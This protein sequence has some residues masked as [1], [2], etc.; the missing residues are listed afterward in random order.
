M[1]S[2]KRSGKFEKF[3]PIAWFRSVVLA[4]IAG[5]F[6]LAINLTD[7]LANLW[8]AAFLFACYVIAIERTASEIYKTYIK[9]DYKPHVVCAICHCNV[10]RVRGKYRR[11]RN[12]R[13]PLERILTRM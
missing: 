10:L 8:I 2:G 1:A 11:P 13:T 7:G 9:A 6:G 5:L 3:S 12:K 4:L